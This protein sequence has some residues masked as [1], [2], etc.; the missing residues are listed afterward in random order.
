MFIGSI[1]THG[2]IVYVYFFHSLCRSSQVIYWKCHQ[3]TL[4]LVCSCMG[5]QLYL[6]LG[7]KNVDSLSIDK[8]KICRREFQVEA[9]ALSSCIHFGWLKFRRI[10]LSNHD[11]IQRCLLPRCFTVFYF[12][13]Y[14][15][16]FLHS[17]CCALE[18]VSKEGRKERWKRTKIQT[19]II[20]E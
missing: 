4:L 15:F 19:E 3:Y 7:R 14:V 1:F 5:Y 9:H 13:A 8:N 2:M 6:S 20:L 11:L 10:F 18:D 12:V 16:D 17:N